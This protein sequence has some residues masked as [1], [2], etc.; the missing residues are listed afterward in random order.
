[1]N[2]DLMHFYRAKRQSIYNKKVGKS[3]SPQRDSKKY[4][5]FNKK[6]SEGDKTNTAL[7]YIFSVFHPFLP[8][9][10]QVPKMTKIICVPKITINL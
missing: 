8:F 5:V 10:M 9:K 2:S 4:R 7:T 6:K 1:M 3:H